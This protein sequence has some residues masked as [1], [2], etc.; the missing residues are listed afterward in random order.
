MAAKIADSTGNP[1][2][3]ASSKRANAAPVGLGG[4]I[5]RWIWPFLSVLGIVAWMHFAQ[6][7]HVLG[8]TRVAVAWA[9]FLPVIFAEVRFSRAFAEVPVKRRRY[10]W[11]RGVVLA[12]A[13]R[14]ALWLGLWRL[15][16]IWPGELV[17]HPSWYWIKW[18]GPRF[19]VNT[20]LVLGGNWPFTLVGLAI[21]VATYIC[22]VTRRRHGRI[23]GSLLLPVGLAI[24][25]FAE[26][27]A[28]GGVGGLASYGAILSQPGVHREERLSEL[29]GH[30]R[31]VCV[32][33]ERQ[34]LFVSY[35]CTLCKVDTSLPSM[36]RLD[37]TSGEIRTF[38][39]GPIREFECP[40]GSAMIAVAPWHDDRAYLIDRDSFPKAKVLDPDWRR[41]TALWEPM[42]TALDEVHRRL[43]VAN[44]VQQAIYALDIDTG[45]WAGSIDLGKTGAVTRYGVAAQSMVQPVAGGPV[46]FASGPGQNLYELDPG[47]FTITRSI[48]LNDAAGTAIAVD[49]VGGRL[50]YQASL[51]DE[52]SEVDLKTFTVS[53]V[54]AGERFARGLAFDATRNALYEITYFSGKVRAFDLASG[55]VR[56]EL[57]AGGRP[58]SVTLADD[59]LWINSMAGVLSVDLAQVWGQTEMP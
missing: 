50:W 24:G 52:L 20:S 15:W 43:F 34:A 32:D 18:V 42:S 59:T 25:V 36:Y 45:K 33:V 58:N 13:L 48:P 4:Q 38:E 29:P 57:S 3:G 9:M 35:G 31:D 12:T 56:W 40:L 10:A 55:E 11:P 47:T 49:A 22:I 17:Q 6:V 21:W 2:V 26:L 41:H 54:L 37:L 39:S 16:V 1:P 8:H 46:Y 14:C 53:R 27:Y 44:D 51:T 23:F 7:L 28:F 5:W 19:D 30:P